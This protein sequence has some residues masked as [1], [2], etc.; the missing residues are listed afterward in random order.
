MKLA[1]INFLCHLVGISFLV[2]Q[3]ALILYS[4]FVPERFFC[5]APY[6]EH[7]RYEVGV[8][9]DGV[10]LGQEEVAK[11][12]RYPAR[13]WE[14]RAMANIISQ[15]RQYETTYGRDEAA[16]VVLNYQINGHEWEAW[17]WPEG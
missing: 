7:S 5:W 15:I 13:G 14:P 12:Y 4:R 6:D 3:L 2:V 9:I 16:T 8:T 1:R 17:Q 10:P 11:R